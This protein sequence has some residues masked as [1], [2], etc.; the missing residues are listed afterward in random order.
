MCNGQLKFNI[1]VITDILRV[2]Q[3]YPNYRYPKRL[4]SSLGN[5]NLDYCKFIFVFDGSGHSVCGLVG[6]VR[7]DSMLANRNL[8]RF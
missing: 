1:L 7:V 4:A 8:D 2:L 5:L 6:S 3:P